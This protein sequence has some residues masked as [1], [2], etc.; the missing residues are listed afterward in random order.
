MRRVKCLVT[1][2]AILSSS[3]FAMADDLTGAGQFLCSATTVSVCGELGECAG[4]PPWALNIPQFIEVDLEKRMLSTTA[5]SGQARS[6]PIKNLERADGMIAVQG[7]EQGR[8]FSFLIDQ[9]TGF[10]SIAVARDGLGVVVFAACTPMP[11][12]R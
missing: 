9:K 3:S 2:L 10:A 4:G 8:A 1:L 6:T 7:F 5:A 12:S 11:A